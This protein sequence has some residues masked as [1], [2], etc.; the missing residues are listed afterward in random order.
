MTPDLAA[1]KIIVAAYMYYVLDDSPMDDGEYDKLSQYVADHWDQLDLVR[2]WQ[3]GSPGDIRA[4]GM[5]I[6]FTVIAVC[7]ARELFWKRNKRC[8]D[9]PYPHKWKTDRTMKL[10]Y[11]TAVAS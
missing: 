10:R 6:K 9:Y 2:Q 4:S 5:S 8:S 7:A 11:V 3:L 1:R